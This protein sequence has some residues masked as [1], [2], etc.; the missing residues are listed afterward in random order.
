MIGDP[1][2]ILQKPLFDP[3]STPVKNYQANTRTYNAMFSFSSPGMKFD[4]K[5]T[6][7]GGPLTL[8]LHGHTCH[9]IRTMLPEI[10]HPGKYAQLYIFDPGNEIQNW[11]ECFR[12]NKHIDKAIVINLSLMLDQHN[13]HAKAFRMAHDMLQHQNVNDLKLRIIS[14]RLTDGRLYNKPTISKVAALIVG[15]I[16]LGTKQDIIIQA[17]GGNLQR[18][19]EFHPS[20]PAFQYPLLFPFGED[21]YKDNILHAYQGEI[22]VTKRNRQTVME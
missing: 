11:M 22:I 9:R 7:G 12:D 4:T 8:R 5:F 20:Y 14:D 16:N 13:V 6:K 10:G 15:D 1:P 3:A 18:I 19:D 2:V 17:R 21:G